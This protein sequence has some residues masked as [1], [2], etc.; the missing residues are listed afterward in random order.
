MDSTEQK[1][2]W[3]LQTP[4]NSQSDHRL[5]G[6]PH[7]TMEPPGQTGMSAQHPVCVA[8]ST[9]AGTSEHSANSP[10]LLSAQIASVCLS[11]LSAKS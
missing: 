1:G 4:L 6:L 7:F 11:G 2:R 9:L 10:A 8:A 5:G 3:W